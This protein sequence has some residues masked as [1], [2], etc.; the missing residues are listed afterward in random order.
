MLN[1]VGKLNMQQQGKIIVYLKLIDYI[2]VNWIELDVIR[3]SY[4]VLS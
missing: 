3:R 1:I 2:Y 4:I